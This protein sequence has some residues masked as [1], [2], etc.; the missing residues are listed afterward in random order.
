MEEY[1]THLESLEGDALETELETLDQNELIELL[2]TGLVKKAA[3]AI[4][5]RFS[6]AGRLAAVKKKSQRIKDK[7][8]IAQTKTKNIAAKAKLKQA[9]SDLKT[10]RNPVMAEYDPESLIGQAVMELQGIKG[11][12]RRAAYTKAAAQ[13]M[14]SKAMR[15]PQGK[16][17]WEKHAASREKF[18]GIEKRRVGIARANK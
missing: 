16:T 5:K 13:D 1:V 18:K 6:S 14:T 2:G 17:D 4:K 10:A 3:G 15:E 11:P 8:Q 7:T 9:K 12:G